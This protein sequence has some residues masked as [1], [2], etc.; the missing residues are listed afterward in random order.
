MPSS[1]A[2]EYVFDTQAQN[3]DDTQNINAANNEGMTLSVVVGEGQKVEDLTLDAG[4]YCSCEDA[5]IQSNGGNALG[6]LSTLMMMFLTL[7]G[8]SYFI[9]KDETEQG[10]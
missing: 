2:N 1:Y 6:M 3:D 10:A 7:L 8:G 4:I 9:R 5:P